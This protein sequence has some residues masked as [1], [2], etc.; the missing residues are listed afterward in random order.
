M[1]TLTRKARMGIDTSSFL[2]LVVRHLLLVAMHLLLVTSSD[3]MELDKQVLETT[4][5]S[6]EK[7]LLCVEKS[8]FRFNVNRLGST[9]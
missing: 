5:N 4:T 7:D 9:P 8:T 6:E 3:A 1:G 2:L